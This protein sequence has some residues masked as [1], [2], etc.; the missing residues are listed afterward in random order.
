MISS[1]LMQSY[2]LFIKYVAEKRKKIWSLPPAR[3]NPTQRDGSL[4]SFLYP[5]NRKVPDA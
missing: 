1:I 2:T 5:N 4:P 3:D